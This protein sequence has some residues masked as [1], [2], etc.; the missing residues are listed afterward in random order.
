MMIDFCNPESLDSPKLFDLLG[1][2][3]RLDHA[4]FT[5]VYHT[6]R[7]AFE[8]TTVVPFQKDYVRK[9]LTLINPDL[10]PAANPVHPGIDLP[11]WIEVPNSNQTIVLL[12]QDPLR[13]ADYFTAPAGTPPYVVIGTPFSVHSQALR[14]TGNQPRYWAVIERLLGAG[15]GLYLTEVLGQRSARA[16]ACSGHYIQHD[17]AR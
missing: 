3:I 8:Q 2:I 1:R 4:E 15:Y 17:P 11:C 9:A 6:L 5:G 14:T 7:R 10:L 12:G 13:D 16:T